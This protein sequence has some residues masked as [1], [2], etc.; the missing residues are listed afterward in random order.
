MKL[1]VYI[2]IGA[3][4]LIFGLVV[5]IA[6]RRSPFWAR[7]AFLLLGLLGLAYGSLGYFLESH[8]SSLDYSARAT[9][10]HYRTLVAGI[11]I[12][13]FVVLLIS[14]QIKLAMK[15]RQEV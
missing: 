2:L 7:S 5:S 10:D 12:G 15:G 14:G 8:R 3:A 1:T 13:V 11:A 4:A 6:N 9:L